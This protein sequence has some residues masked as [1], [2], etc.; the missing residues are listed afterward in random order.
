MLIFLD[1]DGVMVQGSSWKS[2]ENLSDGFYRFSP[3]A[4]LGLQEIISGTK[5]SIVLTTSHK[6][7]FTPKQW[8]MIFHNRGIDVNSIEKLQTRKIYPNRKE[9]ILTWYKRHREIKDF[10][11]IDDDKSLNGLPEELKKKLILTNSSVGL[12]SDNALEAIK[13]LNPKKKRT[14][15]T[16][17]SLSV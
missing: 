17:K 8:K 3:R 9:E 12:T 10:V 14:T 2:V 5:A 6:N 11:I 1:I 15:S 13:V 7:R 4:V 16:K